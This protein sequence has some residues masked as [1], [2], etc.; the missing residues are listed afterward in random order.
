M[1]PSEIFEMSSWHCQGNEVPIMDVKNETE[2]GIVFKSQCSTGRPIHGIGES[3]G[4]QR[5]LYKAEVGDYHFMLGHMKQLGNENSIE[6]A[7]NNM[8]LDFHW[9]GMIQF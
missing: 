6:L 7:R 4:N 9:L 2:T 5:K 8:K 3:R 1:P